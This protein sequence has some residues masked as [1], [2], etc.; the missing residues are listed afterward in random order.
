MSEAVVHLLCGLNGAGKTTYA[1]RLAAQ[2]PAVRFGLD[3]WMLRLYPYR[4]DTAEYAEQAEV[5][6]ELFWETAVQALHTESDVVLDWNQWSRAR[7]A[8]WRARAAEAGFAARL[9]YIRVPVETAVA[10]AEARSVEGGPEAHVLD[11]AAV[12]HLA[13]IFEPPT[14]GEGLPMTVIDG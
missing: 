4:Y 13:S 8:D 1:R 9:H 6:K 10:R 3:E 2:L 14:A 5:C 7:R 11:G 12:R